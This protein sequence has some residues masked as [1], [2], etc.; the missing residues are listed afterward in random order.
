MQETFQEVSTI[1]E[2][3]NRTPMST[4]EA[5]RDFSALKRIKTFSRSTMTQERLN[6]YGIMSIEKKNYKRDSILQ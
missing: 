3:I 4:S 1:L 5:E 2:M 6:A